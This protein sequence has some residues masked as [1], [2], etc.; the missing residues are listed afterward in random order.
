MRAALRSLTALATGLALALAQPVQA[1]QTDHIVFD[2]VLGGIKAGELVIDGKITAG[3]Y[4]AQG[5]MQ[6]TG[7]AGMLKKIR[8]E[9]AADGRFAQGRFSPRSTEVLS[10]RGDNRSRNT[11]IYNGGVPVSVIHEPPRASRPND[12]DPAKQGGTIDPLT[13]LYAVLRDVPPAE[14][15][16]L[17]VTM[18]DGTKRSEVALSAPRPSGK[19]VTCAGEYRRIAGFSDKEMAE[20]TRFPFTLTYAPTADGAHLQVVDISTETILGKGRLK[21]R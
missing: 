9:A 16:K 8:Y 13:A 7:L 5:M 18:F 11:V 6:T 10:Q 3:R 20:K 4:G 14:A 1:D 15:C 2:V 17:S 19:G 21:R 12:V